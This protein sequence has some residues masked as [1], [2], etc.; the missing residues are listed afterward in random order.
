MFRR[1]WPSANVSFRKEF[2]AGTISFI[3]IVY[4]IA[5]NA[6]ILKD[7]GIPV[8]AGILATIFSCFAGCLIMGLWAGAPL[9]VVPGMG[10]NAM[11]TYGIVQSMGLSWQ[12]ALGAVFVSGLLFALVAFTPLSGRITSAMP[13]S[14][15]EATSVGIGLFLTF[16]GLQKGGIV[17]AN[18]GTFVTLGHLGEPH[19]LLTLAT[20]VL[21]LVL[22]VRN[23]PGGFLISIVL[24]TAVS[25]WLGLSHADSQSVSLQAYLGVLGAMSF[26]AAFTWPFWI[27]ACSL[28]LVVVFENIGLI[29]GQLQSSEQPG[30]FGRSLQAASLATAA[31]GLLGTSPP[32]STVESAAGIAAGGRTGLT[33]LTAAVLF[34]ASAFF[35]PWIKLIPD[36][37]IAPVLMIIGGLMISGVQ[38]IRFADFTEGFPAFLTIALIPLTYSIVDGIGF[39]FIAYS[40]LKL[41][42]GKG[43]EPKIATYAISVLFVA[44]FVLK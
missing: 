10:I 29:H 7:A 25:V 44:Y 41:F 37:A 21:A 8:E 1:L 6:A 11:F 24:G 20:L 35:I 43:R 19:A 39:G 15:K 9:I 5:V 40:L 42:A 32:V 16:I 17:V 27:A 23:V 13:A 3:T 28:T 38:R 14:L 22:F 31:S 33:A 26:D 18:A 4:I 30:K 34:L 12:E 2:L 36:S